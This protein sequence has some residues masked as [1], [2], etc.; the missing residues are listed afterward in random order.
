M[1]NF[2]ISDVS[3]GKLNAMVKTVMSQMGIDNAVEAVRRI[4]SG[5]WVVSEAIK[6]WPIDK[7]GIIYIDLPVTTGITGPQWS[8]ML[9]V[10]EWAD[11]LLNSDDFWV[12]TGKVYKIA[13]IP[14]KFFFDKDRKTVNIRKEMDRRGWLHG[15]KISPEVACLLRKYLSNQDIA[16]LGLYWLMTMHEPIKDSD[17][18]SGL[19]SMHRHD[20][21]ILV[22][23]YDHPNYQWDDDNGFVCVVSQDTQD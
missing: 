19:L 1:K 15:N 16:D 21:S 23:N 22:T 14:G 6:R 12:T 13:I 11:D 2:A 8:K 5:D 10:S 4:N 7:D 18:V 9:N 17:G 3:A 20:V